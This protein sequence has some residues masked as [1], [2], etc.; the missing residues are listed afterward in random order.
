[1]AGLRVASRWLLFQSSQ[2]IEGVWVKGKE[3]KGKPL[4]IY[5]MAAHKD[6]HGVE[7][8]GKLNMRP[9]PDASVQCGPVDGRT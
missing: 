5:R 6:K 3:G 7:M 9:Y 2:T 8:N 4:K 1:M